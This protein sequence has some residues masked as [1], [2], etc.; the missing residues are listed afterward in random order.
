[1]AVKRWQDFTGRTAVLAGDGR[2]FD[3]IAAARGRAAAA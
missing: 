2:G 3:E 1:V